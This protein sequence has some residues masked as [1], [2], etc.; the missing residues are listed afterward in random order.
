MTEQF[1]YFSNLEGLHEYPIEDTSCKFVAFKCDV[2]GK[3]KPKGYK[4]YETKMGFDAP[5]L[6]IGILV[7]GK[8]TVH[9]L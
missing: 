7:A 3:P 9:P 8:V 6:Y 2:I 5:S 1:L 4:H